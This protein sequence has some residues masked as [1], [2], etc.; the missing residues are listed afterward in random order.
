MERFWCVLMLALMVL[1]PTSAF[2]GPAE[3]AGAT[4][5]Q[6]VSA[7]N[8]NNVDA[9]LSLY[10]ADATMV[11][12]VG[13]RLKE[14]SGAIRS[15]YAR[16]A[17]SG[18]KVVIGERKIVMLDD[19]IA[20]VAGFYEFSAIRRGE[21]RSVPARFTM[22][23]IKRGQNWL[24]EHHHSSRQRNTFPALVRRASVTNRPPVWLP[25]DMVEKTERSR[26]KSAD[27]HAPSG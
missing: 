21:R 3:E 24:I 22:V 17:N 2:S 5:D 8:T 4:V 26:M 7:F 12:T 25:F 14:G 6:W 11:G 20:Y 15:Y 13:L 27:Q 1:I 16:L 9:L 18:D 19:C 10:A 23:L